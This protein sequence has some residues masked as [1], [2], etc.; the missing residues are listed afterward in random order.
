MIANP[1]EGA[2]GFAAAGDEIEG[3]VRAEVQI[4]EVERLPA[5]ETS[6]LPM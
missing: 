2:L 4:S 1:V 6:A 5:Q 3:A